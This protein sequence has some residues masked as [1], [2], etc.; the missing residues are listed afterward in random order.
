[1]APIAY[2]AASW[3]FTLNNYNDA[4]IS[5]LVGLGNDGCK[6]L[7]FGKERGESGTP[8]LQGFVVFKTRR[9]LASC[10][11]SIGEKCHVERMRG[12]HLQA[13][14]YCKKDGDFTEFG[15]IPS[16]GLRND[17]ADVVESCYKSKSLRAVSTEHPEL[18]IRYGRGIRDWFQTAEV[19]P[20]RDFK[21]QVRV[22]VGPPGVG[23]SRRGLAEASEF[24][25]VYYKPDG[26]WWD[27]Y[28]GQEA[29][30][31]DD[32]YGNYPYHAMLNALDRY[33]VRVPVK[34]SFVQLTALCFIITSNKSPCKW[35]K[36]E[37]VDDPSALYRRFTEYWYLS[38]LDAAPEAGET[39]DRNT[40]GD[41]WRINY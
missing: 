33:P 36:K 9:S 10:K 25:R 41:S 34:G 40:T 31:F 4:D 27:G 24:G 8:H 18:F 5:R 14:D 29:V 28:D 1:M 16:P 6:Y 13:S 11:E 22:Y 17:L 26:P 12:T 35:W 39:Y 30:I 23:K 2:K 38:G 19:L 7:V 3:C 32:F 20:P 15:T 21:P 37:V